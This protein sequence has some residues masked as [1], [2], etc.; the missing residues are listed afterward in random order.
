MEL[1]CIQLCGA[2]HN[3]WCYRLINGFS[4]FI[5]AGRT[6]QNAD[7]IICAITTI[8]LKVDVWQHIQH[9]ITLLFS[10]I[11]KKVIVFSCL[12]QDSLFSWCVQAHCHCFA[13]VQLQCHQL[14]TIIV[15]IVPGIDRLGRQSCV[16]TNNCLFSAL[17]TRHYTHV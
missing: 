1:N 8:I 3:S 11:L 17:L 13:V 10:Q 14:T 12:R 6:R 2:K 7:S 9:I 16:T 5:N 15:F 4:A